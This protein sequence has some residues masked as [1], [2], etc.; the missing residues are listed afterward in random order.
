VQ[1]TDGEDLSALAFEG[2]FAGRHGNPRHLREAVGGQPDTAPR[3]A[4]LVE[5]QADLF[6]PVMRCL[7][8]GQFFEQGQR[9]GLQ[10][11]PQAFLQRVFERLPGK[12][13]GIVEIGIGESR[14]IAELEQGKQRRL[15]AL[16]AP[17]EHLGAPALTAGNR[18]LVV[19]AC[20]LPVPRRLFRLPAQR[21]TVAIAVAPLP[22]TR[23][24][25]QQHLVCQ[26]HVPVVRVG[27]KALAAQRIDQS[28]DQ[29]IL[30]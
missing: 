13:S 18:R 26:F 16:P 10:E 22:Q 14:A 20:L 30:A 2:D 6:A 15:L 3:I 8:T 1:R 9:L 11:T 25:D 5:S 23:P 29:R 12:D 21:Q 19:L 4:H 17:G 7:V 27:Q 28:A 24:M